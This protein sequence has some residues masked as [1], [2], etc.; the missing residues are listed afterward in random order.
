MYDSTKLVDVVGVVK[1]FQW[2]NPH[3]ILW[4]TKDGESGHDPE[5]WTI[6][7]PTSTGNLSRMDWS[8]RS[9]VPGDRV[10]VEINPLRDGQHG[11]SFKKVTIAATGKVLTASPAGT[12]PPAAAGQAPA[13]GAAPAAMPPPAAATPT[14]AQ[15]PAAAPAAPEA[16]PASAKQNGCACVT[17]GHAAGSGTVMA[18]LLCA[19]ALSLARKRRVKPSSRLARLRELVRM[20]ANQRFGRQHE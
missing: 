14:P 17:V 8:K 9:L 20:L 16:K 7:L 11:G 2:T 12:P 4:V 15:P 18:W 3:V 19:L 1:E 5:L 10:T 13:Q 6:E